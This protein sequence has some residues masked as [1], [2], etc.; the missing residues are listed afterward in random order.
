MKKETWE[1]DIYLEEL[2]G[3]IEAN[4]KKKGNIGFILEESDIDSIE[5]TTSDVFN[6]TDKKITD[7]GKIQIEF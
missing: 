6:Q 2:N 4:A 3:Q 5:I 1:D 7:A